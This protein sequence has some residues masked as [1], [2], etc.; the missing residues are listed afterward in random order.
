M[1]DLFKLTADFVKTWH[2]APILSWVRAARLYRAGHY[3]S[4]IPHYERGLQ[5]HSAHS[6]A[7]FARYELAHCLLKVQRFAEA[8]SHLRLL[9]LQ[10]PADREPYLRLVKLTMWQG[11]F[12]EAGLMAARAA[13]RFQPDAEL[14]GLA[15]W[16]FVNTGGCSELI[17]EVLEL[18]QQLPAKER[19]G[20]P[21]I[22]AALGWHWYHSGEKGL[23]AR[24]VAGVS[25]SRERHSVEAIL[26]HAE[27]LLELKHTDVAREHLRRALALR[28]GYPL[29]LALL[30]KTYLV[31]ESYQ[32]DHAAQLA[33]EACR[34]SGWRSARM[35]HLYADTQHRLGEY[36]TAMMMAQRA[37]HQAQRVVARYPELPA[38][39]AL[40]SQLDSRTF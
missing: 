13:Q 9:I 3:E 28:P 11:L 30:A 29:T 26:A 31:S 7:S 27:I 37:H 20:T 40:I 14:V 10:H 33:L 22:R 39:E 24:E 16:C 25:L 2:S 19:Q 4:A 34:S 38:L 35:L 32:P 5:K 23:G 15:L 36:S 17:R 12:H 6:A 18:S 21:L 8:E 1:F